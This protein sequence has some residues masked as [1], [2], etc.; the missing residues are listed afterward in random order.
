MTQMTHMTR[1]RRALKPFADVYD[2]M[3]REGHSP[4]DL[5]F[6][7]KGPQNQCLGFLYIQPSH[8]KQ[9]WEALKNAVVQEDTEATRAA[10]PRPLPQLEFR[11]E[12]IADLH[13]DQVTEG[14]SERA[15]AWAAEGWDIVSITDTGVVYL[16]RDQAPAAVVVA[17]AQISQPSVPP[18]M[19]LVPREPMPELVAAWWRTKNGGGSDYDAYRAVIRAAE[20]ER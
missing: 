12:S 7:V 17:A 9:A 16:R 10:V 3:L 13:L 4:G 19:A 20:G 15:N 14:L 18:G 8:F 2:W 5:A 6:M 11:R 1:L